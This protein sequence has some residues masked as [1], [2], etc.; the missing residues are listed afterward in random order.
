M[1]P[2]TSRSPASVFR[3]TR[4]PGAAS[5]ARLQPLDLF[6]LPENTGLLI[7]EFGVGYG[8]VLEDSM[9]DAGTSATFGD[10]L[11]TPFGDENITPIVDFFLNDTGSATAVPT[12][13]S[14]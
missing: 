3:W 7:K 12:D 5:T 10:F 1:A 11:L 13:D 4:S 8:N 2:K 14:A 9:N 6:L